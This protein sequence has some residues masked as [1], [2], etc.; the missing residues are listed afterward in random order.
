MLYVWFATKI[1][2]LTNELEKEVNCMKGK[3]KLKTSSQFFFCNGDG[4]SIKY[5]N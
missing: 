1:L 4:G 3:V 2:N 5:F